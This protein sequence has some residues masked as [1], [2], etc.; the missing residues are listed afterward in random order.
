MKRIW[1]VLLFYYCFAASRITSVHPE[2]ETDVREVEIT[3]TETVMV[4]VV[5]LAED[6]PVAVKRNGENL[7]PAVIQPG[8]L[9][10]SRASHPAAVRILQTENKKKHQ[11]NA[12]I[13]CLKYK[14][15]C[16]N[17]LCAF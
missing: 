8:T 17:S 15:S 12:K 5:L 13:I 10:H 3:V 1:I 14:M 6:L 9:S 11:I 4:A 16:Y 2:L 7:L